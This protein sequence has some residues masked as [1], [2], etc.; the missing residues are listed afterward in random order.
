MK[1]IVNVY[2]V[3]DEI[4][5]CGS[6]R[7]INDNGTSEVMS[8]TKA[9]ELALERDLDLVEINSKV[10]PH[11]VKLCVFEKYLYELK[12]RAKK[13]KNV[14][15]PIKEIQLSVNIAKHDLET[16]AKQARAFIE[17]GHKIKATLTMRGRELARRNDNKQVML[18]FILMLEDITLVES[19]K[20]ENNKT[21]VILKQKK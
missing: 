9:R 7:L 3:N 19:M 1:P 20:D 16:K 21:I 8:L 5:P 13:C 12:K 4:K 11:I 17:K 15:L 2:R 10:E 14:S 6:V 18:D